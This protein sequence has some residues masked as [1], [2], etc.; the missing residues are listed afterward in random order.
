MAKRPIE[1]VDDI[2]RGI[3]SVA[4]FI[5][6]PQDRA[7]C[8]FREID[9]DF[10]LVATTHKGYERIMRLPGVKAYEAEVW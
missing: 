9:V 5:W 7:W 6:W 2:A 1:T 10:S 4:T 3:Y 8:I